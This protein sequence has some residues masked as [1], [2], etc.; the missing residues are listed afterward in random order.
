M[1]NIIKFRAW[2]IENQQMIHNAERTYDYKCQGL[3][4]M[5]SN[6]GDVLDSDN[7]I[8]MQYIGIKDDLGVE[9]YFDDILEVDYSDPIGEFHTT[10]ITI[11]TIED[12]VN[13]YLIHANR[14]KVIGNIHENKGEK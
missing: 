8:V 1:R 11:K 10:T 9:I 14:I 5:E 12:V 2:D 13:P 4:C 7:Y 3:G 6:F